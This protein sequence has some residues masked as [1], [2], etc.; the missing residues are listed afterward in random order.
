VEEEHRAGLSVLG[1]SLGAVGLF[2]LL[3]APGKRKKR[4]SSSARRIEGRRY[5]LYAFRPKKKTAQTLA[6]NLRKRG[7][8]ARVLRLKRK[9]EYGQRWAVFWIP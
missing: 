8:S 7:H 3:A 6:Q 5:R 9:D 4:S 2:L 1:L